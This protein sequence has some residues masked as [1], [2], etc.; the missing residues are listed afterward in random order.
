MKKYKYEKGICGVCGDIY[1][2]TTRTV[3]KDGETYFMHKECDPSPTKNYKVYPT[4]GNNAN[5]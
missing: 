5:N 3:V 4:G 2:Q 1:K